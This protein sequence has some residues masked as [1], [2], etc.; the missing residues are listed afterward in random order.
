M[1]I[2]NPTI[3]PKRPITDPK[4]SITR[5]LTNKLGSAASEIA[6]VAPAIPTVMPQTRLLTPTVNPA[7][8]TAYPVKRFS[9][10]KA[11]S[12]PAEEIF[13]ESTIEVI[14]PKMATTSQNT[15]DT[16]FL[17][18]TRGTL[19]LAPRILVP[20]MNIPQ[21]APAI[22]KPVHKEIPINDHI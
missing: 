22:L 16:K 11:V 9:L 3:K 6:A 7:Q 1:V 17:V 8:N 19:T 2:N 4:I 18:V 20:V 5:I 13:E 21:A 14:K 15:T 10:E 12:G